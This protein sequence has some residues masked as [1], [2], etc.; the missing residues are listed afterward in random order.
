MINQW[1]GNTW[2]KFGAIALAVLSTFLMLE[3]LGL[4]DGINAVLNQAIAWV[5]SLGAM[6]MVAFIGIY[7]L[8][9]ILFISGA[10]LTLG[11]GALFG[12]IQGSILV[13]IAST[14]AAA[15]TFLIGRYGA[16][17]WV[18][19]KIESQPKFKAVDRAVAQEGWKI[20]GLTRL[21]PLF[22]FVF[23]NY[24]FGITKVSFRDYLLASWIGMMPGTIMYVYF[25]AA[26]R[27]VADVASGT[28]DTTHSLLKTALTTLGLVATVIVSL[29]ITKAAQK[30]L[31]AQLTEAALTEETS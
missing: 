13:S 25:G 29:L 16:R 5:D 1:L 10:A 30:S 8:A 21:S 31:Q 23:L 14:A 22:P 27:A 17:Q 28:T 19:S 15:C 20:V 3:T 24:A 12:I 4:F 2:V 26:G 18:A 6:G 11:A 7:I 9:S